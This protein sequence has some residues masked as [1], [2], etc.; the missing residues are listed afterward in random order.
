MQQSLS[1]L[2][3]LL[4]IVLAYAGMG[5]QVL[6]DVVRYE[7]PATTHRM[8]GLSCTGYGSILRKTQP[9]G[10]RTLDG[11]AAVYVSEGVG[12]LETATTGRMRVGGGALMWLYPGVS[13]T[14]A[15]DAPGWSEQW[16]LFE[17]PLA[18]TCEHLGLLSRARPLQQVGPGSDPAVGGGDEIAGL[19]RGIRQDFA[20]GGPLAGVRAAALV[21]RLVAVAHDTGHG[22]DVEGAVLPRD[23]QFALARLDASAYRPVDLEALAREV[24]VGYSTLRRRF[25]QATGYSP[26]EYILRVRLSR[27]K[28]LL[29]LTSQSVTEIARAVGFDDPYY[30][31]R[32]F[33]RKE[34]VSPLRFRAQQ[35][36]GVGTLDPGQELRWRDS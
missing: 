6:T 2:D 10:P 3:F 7:T 28:E 17:G 11:Y 32:L 15:P 9:C 14:Y 12:W 34:G 27:A 30:F 19:F 20:A 31:S 22:V 25:K 4:A 1:I 35:Q 18:E 8:L 5:E 16:V 13:H 36:A 33:R 29:T 23:V 26:K 24:H 21:F